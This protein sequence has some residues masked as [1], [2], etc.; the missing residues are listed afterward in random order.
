MR[1]PICAIALGMSL[2]VGCSGEDVRDGLETDDDREQSDAVSDKLVFPVFDR[3]GVAEMTVPFD[4][5]TFCVDQNYFNPVGVAGTMTLRYTTTRL[6][7]AQWVQ[8][9]GLDIGNMERGPAGISSPK[10]L[11]VQLESTNG[12]AWERNVNQGANTSVSL[13][14]SPQIPWNPVNLAV[15]DVVIDSGSD[16]TPTFCQ[17]RVSFELEPPDRSVE[18][19][20]VD[21]GGIDVRTLPVIDVVDG[22]QYGQATPWRQTIPSPI[23]TNRIAGFTSVLTDGTLGE[24]LFEWIPDTHGVVWERLSTLSTNVSTRWALTGRFNDIPGGLS[25]VTAISSSRFGT[26]LAVAVWKGQ[27]GYRR[28]YP[29]DT[30]QPDGVRWNQPSAWSVLNATG[31]PTGGDPHAGGGLITQQGVIIDASPFTWDSNTCGQ[32]TAHGTYLQAWWRSGDSGQRGYRRIVPVNGSGDPLFSC[33]GDV[34]FMGGGPGG[35]RGQSMH[36]LDTF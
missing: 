2:L 29:T 16:H 33:A 19:V 21:S 14:D 34:T 32:I 26:E 30:G 3:T 36:P 35:L 8:L 17:A 9:Q 25:G 24:T 7:Q 28:T 18:Q 12:L 22:I 27:I 10:V 13:V 31:L 6:G 11:R 5:K 23:A 4:F 1:L 15:L 20:V